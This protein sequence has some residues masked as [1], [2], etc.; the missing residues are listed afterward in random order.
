MSRE[1]FIKGVASRHNMSISEAT[2]IV[3]L[4]GDTVFEDYNKLAKPELNMKITR[5]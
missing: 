5:L 1:E 4:I 2:A 3:N